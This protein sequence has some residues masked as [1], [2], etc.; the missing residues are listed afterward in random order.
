MKD[1]CVFCGNKHL[2]ETNT[3]YLYQQKGQMMLVENV[4]CLK[5]DY[6]GEPYFEIQVLKKIENDFKEISS[7]RKNPLQIMEVPLEEY[8]LL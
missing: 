7:K 8:A 5:C 4:P 6:C 2:S 1:C 3:R